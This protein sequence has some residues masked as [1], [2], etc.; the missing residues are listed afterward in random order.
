MGDAVCLI[1]FRRHRSEINRALPND[2]PE[3]ILICLDETFIRDLM[4][5]DRRGPFG[6]TVVAITEGFKKYPIDSKGLLT[7]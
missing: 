2:V 5:F 3:Q 1:G 7:D 6:E 4:Q